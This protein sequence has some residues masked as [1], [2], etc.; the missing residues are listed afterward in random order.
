MTT[1]TRLYRD[2]E[3]VEEDFGLVDLAARL[4]EPGPIAWVD[5]REPEEEAL[6][7]L[8]EVLGL[9][10][11][12]IE[13]ARESRQ[14]P[15]VDHYQGHLFLTV[16]ST[17]V[18]EDGE[19]TTAELGLFVTERTLVTVHDGFDMDAV[20]RRWDTSE[21]R[22][23][24]VGVLLHGILDDVVDGH[25]EAALA[26]EESLEALEDKVFEEHM[27]DRELQRA[28]V[29]LRRSLTGVR[30]VVQPMREVMVALSRDRTLVVDDLRP[31]F[32][33]IRD[34]VAHAAE[35]TDSLRDQLTT[36]RETQLNIQ[37]NRLNLIMKKVT[38][39]AA[40]IA[41]PTAITGF[42]GQNVPYPGSEQPWGFWLST[43]AIVLLS[44]GLYLMFRRKDWL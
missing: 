7:R 21:L 13:D 3:L 18:G 34:H 31:Y 14:R 9:H 15:K 8:G 32:A 11:L 36:V 40:I 17:R 22:N 39:W 38:G 23:D 29:R 30:R 16:Y 1:R 26:L 10:Q 24:R 28:T 44:G 27:G 20:L 25:L 37:S 6:S 43:A 5:L 33:D 41:I 19:L 12:A 35:M 42:Y 2:G 4:A